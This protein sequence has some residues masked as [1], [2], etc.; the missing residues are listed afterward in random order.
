M[1]GALSTSHATMTDGDAPIATNA[2]GTM[3]MLCTARMRILWDPGRARERRSG[4]GT[5]RGMVVIWTPREPVREMQNRRVFATID[6]LENIA[7]DGEVRDQGDT[8]DT[9]NV[10]ELGNV[11]LSHRTANMEESER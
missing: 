7:P 1:N 4:G 9:V 10:I 2:C 8:A 3:T 6:G 11:I 5:E